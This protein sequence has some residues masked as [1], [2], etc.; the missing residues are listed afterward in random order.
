MRLFKNKQPKLKCSCVDEEKNTDYKELYRKALQRLAQMSKDELTEFVCKSK[1]KSINIKHGDIS[2]TIEHTK[3]GLT[4]WRY[5][6]NGDASV[7][8]ISARSQNVINIE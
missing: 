4:I 5:T 1:K 8:N 3:T 2:Y 7:I 6:H